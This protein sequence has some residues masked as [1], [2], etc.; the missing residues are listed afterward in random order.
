MEK[1]AKKGDLSN[2]VRLWKYYFDINNAQRDTIA[3]VKWL[4]MAA[5]GG[6]TESEFYLGSCYYRG[7]N[8]GI[9]KDL[10]RAVYYTK[11]AAD[12]GLPIALSAM[13]YLY[14]MG[15]GVEKNLDIANNY[16]KQAALKGDAIGMAQYGAKLITDRATYDQGM[17]MLQQAAEQD[18]VEAQVTL[19]AQYVTKKDYAKVLK[20]A[21][22][23]AEQGN[24]VA[25]VFMA[26]IYAAGEGGLVKDL[27]QAHYWAQKAAESG[28][29][30]GYAALGMADVEQENYAFAKQYFDKGAELNDDLSFYYLGQMYYEGLGVEKS[31]DLAIDYLKRAVD[32]GNTDAKVILSAIYTDEGIH[33][34][35]SQQLATE[36]AE[37][38]DVRGIILQAEN[39]LS[40]NGVPKNEEKAFALYKQAADLNDDFAKKR[41]VY[42][43]NNGVGTN[44]NLK[45]AFDLA[46]ELA[47]KDDAELYGFV[48]KSYYWGNG[49]AI[50]YP[51]ARY[52]GEKGAMLQD[53]LSYYTMGLYYF[54]GK[55]TTPNYAKAL[56]YFKKGAQ[57]GNGDC[58]YGCFLCHHFGGANLRNFTLAFKE[59][60]KALN[61]LKNTS[62]NLILAQYN[63]AICYYNGRG[64]AVNKAKAFYWFKKAA[65]NESVDNEESAQKA[66]Y[67]AQYNVA[68][69]Y[70]TG[71]GTTR[72][73]E[74]AKYWMRKAAANGSQ[75]AKKML[76]VMGW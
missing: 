24:A 59:I 63:M 13:A 9:Q 10:P 12:Q 23:A 51:E 30:R 25:Q 68:Y 19:A 44:K 26:T 11:K 22:P 14:E 20:Y 6:D 37:S 55:A 16:Y 40:G 43:Y 17:L 54:D 33:G 67:N 15:E 31:L 35:Q 29:G 56:D 18:N 49:T 38:G 8:F 1:T 71:T 4:K 60:S 75:E 58:Y 52:W 2:Q 72:N 34:N 61:L 73:D 36:L 45:K 21:L 65:E 53:T 47:K 69:C 42:M 62:D 66:K 64:T 28:L 5:D 50:N 7:I 70:G 27:N 32:L 46:L 74:K 41:L 39:Y 57:L 3:G 48:A 76:Q